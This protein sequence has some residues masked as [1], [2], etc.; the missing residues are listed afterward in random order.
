MT[1]HLKGSTKKAIKSLFV[2]ESRPGS[3]GKTR[4]RQIEIADKAWRL[5][6][7]KEIATGR[8]A[9]HELF[10]NGPM[11]A[12]PDTVARLGTLTDAEVLA[13]KYELRDF[14]RSL[15]QANMAAKV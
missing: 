6:V 10:T 5:A 8:R 14:L 2:S 13:L 7:Q 9:L 1:Q 3:N 11:L 15:A 4:Q 12:T